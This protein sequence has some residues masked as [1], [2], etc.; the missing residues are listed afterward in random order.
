MKSETK[1]ADLIW[2][3]QEHLSTG[4]FDELR[5]LGILDENRKPKQFAFPEFT[6][7]R[8]PVA[9]HAV[10]AA[11]SLNEAYDYKRPS[12]FSRALSFDVAAD[13]KVF[14]LGMQV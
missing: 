5:K 2:I 12:S 3:D 6:K 10:H 13:W 11:Q 9:R 7:G 4:E 14:N 1:S 8:K